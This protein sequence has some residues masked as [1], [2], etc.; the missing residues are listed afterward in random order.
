MSLDAM[1]ADLPANRMHQR[2]ELR[3]RIEAIGPCCDPNGCDLE[4]SRRVSA[5]RAALAG[6]R[7]E[8]IVSGLHIEK[9]LKCPPGW[10]PPLGAEADPAKATL[11]KEY[12]NDVSWVD[13]RGPL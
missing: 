9:S 10:P 3:P 1:L 5:N 7:D 11:H 6:S 2:R 8:S 12:I 13:F 4:I